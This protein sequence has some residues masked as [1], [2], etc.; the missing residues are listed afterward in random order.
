LS[1]IGEIF[2]LR[3]YLHISVFTKFDCKMPASEGPPR[4]TAFECVAPH[5]AQKKDSVSGDLPAQ[6]GYA[7]SLKTRKRVE[8]IVG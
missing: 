6:P 8:E 1:K 3:N 7:V 4:A 5:I 2:H